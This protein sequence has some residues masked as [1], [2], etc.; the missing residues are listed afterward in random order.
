MFRAIAKK[1]MNTLSKIS[2]E[3]EDVVGVDITPE[4]IRVAQLDNNKKSWTLTK[5]GYKFVEGSTDLYGIRNNPDI[6]VRKLKQIVGSSKITTTNAAVSIPVSSAIIKV[7]N[8][9]LMTDEELLEAIDTDSLW[10]N[11]IQLSDALDE[12]SIFWQIIKRHTEENSM[13]LLFVASKLSDIE[14]YIDIVRKAGLNPVVVDVR[15]FTLRNAL[16]VGKEQ[17]DPAAPIVLLEFGQHENYLLIIKDDAPF[18]SDIY[19]SDQDR[20]RLLSNGSDFAECQKIYDRLAMQISQILSTYQAKYKVQPVKVIQA[21]STLPTIDNAIDCLRK[22]LPGVDIVPFDAI[23]KTR[24]PENLKEKATAEVNKSV[25]S[26]VLGLA[27]R[28]LDI[29][30]YYQYVT[31]TNNINLLPDRD[32]I[33]NTEKVKTLSKLGL[34]IA[35]ILVIAAG[36]WSFLEIEKEDDALDGLVGEYYDLETERDEKQN[37]LL[38]LR[39]EKDEFDRMLG[40]SKDI[41]SNQNFMYK[42]LSAVNGSVP[43]GVSLTSVIYDGNNALK[44][45][46][47]SINDQNILTFINRLGETSSVERASLMTMS[48]EKKGKKTFKAFT[49][50]CMLVEQSEVISDKEKS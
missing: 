34:V 41:R 7:I 45:K 17:L 23:G 39:S 49:V 36:V 1:M 31:G 44:L 40:V 43:R 15:C 10:E 6:Y 24:I 47:L 22:S 37:E 21:T 27:T 14:S 11:I 48:V 2:V 30:G 20:S 28:K 9:P 16:E 8:L 35:T 19:I 50:R 32:N 38:R 13:D 12:Y 3:K 42:V 26:S 33:K 18:I 25:F 4:N 5:L 29:F 46:G